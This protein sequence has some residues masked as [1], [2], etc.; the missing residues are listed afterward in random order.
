[1]DVQHPNDRDLR[2]YGL[3][4]LAE[5][6]A[7]AVGSHLEVCP[8]C[9]RRAAEVSSDSFLGRLRDA[10]GGR[11]LASPGGREE[12]ATWTHGASAPAPRP[13]QADSIPPGLADHPDYAIRRELGR[14]GMGVVYLAYNRMMGRD[15]V[16]KVI[17]PD[18]MGRPEVF[19]RFQ[20]EIRSVA[21]LRHPNIVTAYSAFRLGGG[22]VFAMEYVDGMDL[23]RLIKV[24]GPLPVVHAAYF[25]H[26]AALG[27]QHAHERGL[28][29]RDIKPHNLML[30]HDGKHR[31]IKILD[32]G[33]A[34]ATREGQVDSALTHEGQTLGTPDYIAPEQIFNAPDVDVRA[35]IYSLGCS[36]YY[37]LAGRPPFQAASLY[38]L[39]QAHISRDAGL[40]DR[41]RADVPSELAA[42]VAKMMAKDPDRRFQTP[43]EVARALTP[44]FK[45][46]TAAAPRPR[47]DV[48]P[49]V[50]V[51][52]A[53]LDG[54]AAPPALPPPRPPKPAPPPEEM[55]KS[56]I[57]FRDTV[58]DRPSPTPV[59]A[60]VP[61]AAL[62]TSSPWSRIPARPAIAVG[63]LLLGLGLAFLVSDLLI[64]TRYGT[65]RVGGLPKGAAV[66]VDG[67]AA[68]IVWTE[69]GAGE[70]SVK[71]G[72]HG[73]EVR[74]GRVVVYGEKI[75]V[76]AGTTF[77]VELDPSRPVPIP[78]RPEVEKR[79]PHPWP[80]TS[81]RLGREMP[82]GHWPLA[83]S[84]DAR[85]L[86]CRRP[87][88]TIG[89][90][91]APD[92]GVFAESLQLRGFFWAAAFSPDGSVLATAGNDKLVHLWDVASGEEARQ[93]RG[94]EQAVLAAAYSPDGKWIASG[95]IDRTLRIWDAATG[96][97]KAALGGHTG[98]IWS[99]AF[100]PDGKWIASGS[101]DAWEDQKNDP[102]VME[103]MLWN[104]E[105]G[106]FRRL[107]GHAM[108]VTSVA[109]SPDGRRLASCSFD[110]TLK[111]WDVETLEC[112]ATLGPYDDHPI[113]AAFSPDGRLVASASR[114]N[115]V[116]VW[117]TR[118]NSLL[119][120]LTGAT[121]SLLGFVQFSPAGRWIFTGGGSLKSW[122]NPLPD[123]SEPK[124]PADA[125]GDGD[126]AEASPAT[127][128]AEVGDAAAPGLG[129]VVAEHVGARNPVSEGFTLD[130][131]P[132]A[133]WAASETADDLG[134]PTWSVPSESP[135]R[136][137]FY[138]RALSNS[139]E[140]DALERGFALV[141]AAR[142]LRNRA[143][144]STESDRF[145]IA[146]A[147]VQ[148][149]PQRYEIALGLTE[150]GDTVVLV[151]EDVGAAGADA[152]HTASGRHVTLPGN[153][154]HAYR[155][156]YKPE[157]KLADLY[158][159][160][161]LALA[162]C[163]GDR[164]GD[165]GEP[166]I[167]FG[168]VN[169][170]QGNFHLVRLAVG[171]PAE[172]ARGEPSPEP[173]R[174]APVVVAR[175]DEFTPMFNGK[176]LA[177]W[178]KN[179]TQGGDWRVEGG[180][181]VGTAPGISHLYSDRGDYKDFRLRVKAKIND[182]G[183]SGVFL[184]AAGSPVWPQNDPRWPGGY[185]AQINSTHRDPIRTGSLYINGRFPAAVR[186]TPIRPGQWFTMEMTAEGDHIVIKVDDRVTADYID[187]QRLAFSGHIALQ[188]HN[189]QTRIEFES[190]EIH[191]LGVRPP[192][193]PARPAL[194][195]KPPNDAVIFVAGRYKVYPERITWQAARR[196]CEEMGGRLARVP[197]AAANDFLIDLMNRAKLDEAWLGATDEEEEGEWRWLDGS[198]LRFSAWDVVQPT[199]RSTRGEPEHYLL[200]SASRRKWNDVPPQGEV[201]LGPPGFICEWPENPASTAAGR[202][203]FVPL[204]D[205]RSLDGW[206]VDRGDPATWRVQD[207][208]LVS[209]GSGDYRD[210]TYLLSDREFSEFSLH[211]EYQLAPDSDGGVVF[212][213]VP[214]E[215][216]SPP[217][218]NLRRF[219]DPP[220]MN[221]RTGAL[222]WRNNGD[223]T[224]YLAPDRPVEPRAAAAW[225][226]MEVEVREGT[227]EVVINGVLAKRVDLALLAREPDAME[228]I[229]R[230]SGRIGF[231]CHTGTIRYR[232]VELRDLTAA[233]AVAPA[234]APRPADA[235]EFRGAHYKLFP[236]KLSWHEAAA[237]CREM[238]GR[239][240]IVRDADQNA[241][242]L[243]LLKERS[244]DAIWLGGTDEQVEKVWVWVDGSPIPHPDEPDIG[245]YTNWNAGQ[246]NNKGDGE[247]YLVMIDTFNK[248]DF[249]GT[250]SDQP[251]V[252]V[253]HAPGF[254]CE[255]PRPVVRPARRR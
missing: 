199:N 136:P 20:R 82:T 208:A 223:G 96:E 149:G 67:E 127:V 115:L 152:A 70:V 228:G 12:A 141:L 11:I 2:S 169:G 239:L 245:I 71:A 172:A 40:L 187:S 123:A 142:A 13:P 159:D 119:D 164:Y 131:A 38:D 157:S 72:P 158:I 181:I 211:L 77:T 246:P 48:T 117:D 186:D 98:S 49:D 90:L 27:L 94:H 241:F 7:E 125:R 214:G 31:V 137:S 251:A 102:A 74:Q 59:A 222:R 100:S 144:A 190:I 110:K 167:G 9:R 227:L 161:R 8:P 91:S 180:L 229:R 171:P 60:P 92:S 182:G 184:R 209:K 22:L 226:A 207:R 154:H 109:F 236:Q 62:E 205:G 243:G 193:K 194:A 177:G 87:D 36:L 192:A 168:S 56:L 132:N 217:E 202:D 64:R 112:L 140:A 225:N 210:V 66:A 111:I 37:F 255:W 4:R 24:K 95:G 170:G 85:R 104:R 148:I 204:F 173:S 6:R 101:G 253:Q 195:S 113:D 160:D 42:L 18:I 163:P 120:T 1:M 216:P 126:A 183:N 165:L 191:E 78:T 3:G 33:L 250:W 124:P 219:D 221:A 41:L 45:K 215:N 232:N 55:W 130:P 224:N 143:P 128:P 54:P 107:D 114:D 206:K 178:T 69:G 63:A 129:A 46:P 196:R 252:S 106:S 39:Y 200:L 35:D 156:V 43:A 244:V 145:P 14:G 203:G 89:I 105:S 26:Q 25:A 162:G 147:Y 83:L 146:K 234:V 188:V 44:F 19:D 79:E 81:T 179:P 235:R 5:A 153:A 15:E 135:R 242:L 116:R 34:K 73:L 58:A 230:R 238:G 76:E 213:A 118:D 52:E 75:A 53:P 61:V 218:I 176:D 21:Q 155:L 51:S 32:F 65:I 220:G 212:R 80:Q 30:T 68:T 99:I 249:K 133:D 254:I 29:H 23:A 150:A 86:A 233:A 201:K 16:L 175:R 138:R 108:R 197:D 17:G 166:R 231:Q 174:P 28:V 237:K 121:R 189:S 122:E 103:L 248:V 134:K 139:Q 57:D 198:P 50:A 151:P 88:G 240:A 84:R 97:N 185:E 93:L 47:P 10:Q 247:N